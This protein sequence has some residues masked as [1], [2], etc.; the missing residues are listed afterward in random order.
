VSAPLLAFATPAELNSIR[1]AQGGRKD[2]LA[3][4]ERSQYLLRGGV[5]DGVDL[6]P[7]ARAV[8]LHDHVR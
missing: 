6:H 1:G 5:A 8:R 4:I 7:V 2:R 3:I